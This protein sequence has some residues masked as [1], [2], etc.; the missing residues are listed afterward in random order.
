MYVIVNKQPEQIPQLL[1]VDTEKSEFN[2]ECNLKK[3]EVSVSIMGKTIEDHILDRTCTVS[4]SDKDIVEIFNNKR[5]L[6]DHLH[7]RS[8]NKALGMLYKKIK[9]MDLNST[10][11]INIVIDVPLK[12]SLS[13]N[14]Y[15]FQLNINSNNYIIAE[16]YVVSLLSLIKLMRLT[17]ILD[18]ELLNE[19][20]F[21]NEI[22]FQ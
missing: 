11:R 9:N 18:I 22:I 7:V 14:N 6:V 15:F 13:W 12:T 4:I 21:D 3:Y 8:Q 20:F 5:S 10:E 19:F 17:G 2:V 16:E 1:F